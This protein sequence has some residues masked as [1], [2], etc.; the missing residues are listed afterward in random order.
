MSTL[1][2]IR[3]VTIL[4]RTS[5][6]DPIQIAELLRRKVTQIDPEFRVSSVS[7]QTALINAQTVRERLLA[8]LGLFFA[9]V[10]LLL[11]SIGLYGV[12]NYSVLQRE[13]ELGTRIALGA[14]VGNIARLVTIRVFAMVMLG[15]VAGLILGMISVRSIT[16]LLYGVKAT[17]PAM[18]LVPTI[19]LLV[20]AALAALPAVARAARI[21]PVIMLRAE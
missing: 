21:D 7:A 9:A 1:Q 6:D 19:V 12:L 10:A 11:A 14:Q 13:R 18:L 5:S 15:G 16:T 2:P 20:A 4:V 3:G 8:S 17:D